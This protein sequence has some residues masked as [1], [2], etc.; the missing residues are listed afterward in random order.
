MTSSIDSKNTRVQPIFR[1][2]K[3]KGGD[4]WLT[5][6]IALASGLV[7]VP[8]C[9]PASRVHLDPEAKVPATSARLLDDEERG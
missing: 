8:Q 2:L 1:W 6:L 3:K 4:G 9:G 5:T 7:H